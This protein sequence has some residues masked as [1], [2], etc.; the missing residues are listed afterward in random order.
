MPLLV[1]SA[2]LSLPLNQTGIATALMRS[3]RF[4]VGDLMNL[5]DLDF[6]ILRELGGSNL[7]RWNVRESYSDIARKLGVDEE[8]VRARVKKA[9]ERGLIPAWRIMVNPLLIDC[10]EAHL[11]IE[12]RDEERKAEAVSKIK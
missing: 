1:G 2:H 9:S 5:D 7:S 10:R 11:E 4:C 12:V 3:P 6:G 8:T